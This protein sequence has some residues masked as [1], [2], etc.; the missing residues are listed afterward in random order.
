M[1]RCT[2]A[3]AILAASIGFIFL[4]AQ[5]TPAQGTELLVVV[6]SGMKAPM[7][8][9]APRIEHSIGRRLA[10]QFDASKVLKD[11]IQSGEPFDVAILTVDDID[12]LIKQGKIAA[13][14]RAEIARTGMGIGIR[15]GAPKPNI[16]TPEALKRT[17]LKARSIA[18]NPN[19]VL[20]AHI[21]EVFARLGIAEDV[22][23][24]LIL[25][26]KP[27]GPQMDVAD[28]KA[29]L[30]IMLTPEIEFFKG[31]E[32]AGPFPEDLQSYTSFSAGVA[33]STH[34]ADAAKALIKFITGPAAAP[35]LKAKGFEPR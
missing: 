17:L 11:K 34:N 35:T 24:K 16:S 19:G 4:F 6:S 32:F 33:T 20:F 22:K 30:V 2:I 13:G 3:A 25:D 5:K 9:L 28:G 15:T 23:S 29:E 26:V 31:V 10:T 12:Y 18:I 7:E 1:R 21:N 14:T 27:G 8:E